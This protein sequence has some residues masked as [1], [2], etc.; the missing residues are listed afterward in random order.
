MEGRVDCVNKVLLVHPNIM[1]VDAIGNLLQID[2]RQ[3]PIRDDAL[4]GQQPLP[5]EQQL[6]VSSPIWHLLKQTEVQ[7]AVVGLCLLFIRSGQ[8]HLVRHSE[9]GKETTRQTEKEVG[10][11]LQG[12]NRS[13]V[14]QVHDGSGEQRKMEETGYEVICG[15]QTTPAVKG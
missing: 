15:A 10:R 6:G 12:M 11:Q 5:N 4:A 14:R 3:P 7:T 1:N 13:G 2:M 8:N 9:R